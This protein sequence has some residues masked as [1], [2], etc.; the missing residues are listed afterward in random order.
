MAPRAACLL[1]EFLVGRQDWEGA[2]AYYRRAIS[3]SDPEFTPQAAC[4]LG[5]LL[6]Q[7]GDSSGA[8]AAYLRKPSGRI[9]DTRLHREPSNGD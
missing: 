1:A 4:A 8:E 5:E 9:D 7:H 2:A 3:F 6:R